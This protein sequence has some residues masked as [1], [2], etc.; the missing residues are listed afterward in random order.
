[1]TMRSD[2]GGKTVESN[3]YGLDKVQL[4]KNNFNHLDS[5]IEGWGL[6][7]RRFTLIIFLNN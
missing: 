2:D 3:Y 1:M 7:N 4:S 5:D 6:E